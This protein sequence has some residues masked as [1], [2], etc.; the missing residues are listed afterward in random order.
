MTVAEAFKRFDPKPHQVLVVREGFGKDGADT[1]EAIDG[2]KLPT[3]KKSGWKVVEK[4][5][6][7]PKGAKKAKAEINVTPEGEVGLKKR[8]TRKA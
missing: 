7:V 3:Y 8:K 6:P 4:P 1:Y 5:A 2:T